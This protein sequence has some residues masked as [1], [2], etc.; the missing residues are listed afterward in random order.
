MT[1]TPDDDVSDRLRNAGFVCLDDE[2][3]LLLDEAGD[4]IERLRAMIVD[5]IETGIETRRYRSGQGWGSQGSRLPVDLERRARESFDR[6]ER[7]AARLSPMVSAHL[8]ALGVSVESPE[9]AA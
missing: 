2:T 3:L 9:P 4:E 1:R 7:E 6:M 5:Y 8:S